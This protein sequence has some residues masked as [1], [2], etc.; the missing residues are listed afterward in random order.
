MHLIAPVVW[1][2]LDLCLMSTIDQLLYLFNCLK[3]MGCLSFYKDLVSPELDV[4]GSF[5]GV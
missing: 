2:E 4:A 1:F 5:L 3:S